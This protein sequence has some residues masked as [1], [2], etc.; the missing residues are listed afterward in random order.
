MIFLKRSV[1]L[2]YSALLLTA[3]NL[4]LRMAGT[5]FQVYLSRRIGAEGIGLLQLTL[6]VGS[7]AMISGIGGIRTATMYLTAEEL[8][9][10]NRPGLCWMLSGC[11]RYSILCSLSIAAALYFLAP[12]LASKWIGNPSVTG[13]L[14]LFSFFLPIRFFFGWLHNFCPAFIGQPATRQLSRTTKFLLNRHKRGREC[15]FRS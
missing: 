7:L 1:P 13:A 4:V 9:R 14:R 2:F 11:L 5:G 6:S 10:K 12:F 8:G 15:F 3:V